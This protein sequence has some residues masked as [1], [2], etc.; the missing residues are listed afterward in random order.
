MQCGS[1]LCPELPPFAG[2]KNVNHVLEGIDAFVFDA[3]LYP[4]WQSSSV[5]A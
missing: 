5:T 3:V 2:K 4:L 1:K